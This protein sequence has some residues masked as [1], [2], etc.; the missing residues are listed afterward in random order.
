[1][2]RFSRSLDR[3]VAENGTSAL[4]STRWRGQ[5]LAAEEEDRSDIADH[6]HDGR[7]NNT[8]GLRDQ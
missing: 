3:A 5:A 4:V 8:D 6:H 2:G 7:R 1:M